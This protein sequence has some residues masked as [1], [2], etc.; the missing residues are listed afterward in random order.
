MYQRALHV[1][2]SLVEPAQMVDADVLQEQKAHA[3]SDTL[4]LTLRGMPVTCE[5]RGLSRLPDH[6][7][8]EDDRG[9]KQEFGINFIFHAF[10]IL[11]AC[12]VSVK[13]V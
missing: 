13:H 5:K 9:N 12:E 3:R 7:K 1:S 2:T 11:R 6:D 8:D 4:A 10:R